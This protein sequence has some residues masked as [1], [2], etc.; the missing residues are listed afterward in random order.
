[1]SGS[2]SASGAYDHV[3]LGYT[4]LAVL[5]VIAAI[6]LGMRSCRAIGPL[7]WSLLLLIA[8]L[9]Y[10]LRVRV[11]DTAIHLR[12]GV[13]LV[14]RT[15]PLS[16]VTAS[17]PIR[18]P[19]LGYGIRWGPRGTL[20]NVSGTHAVQL[21]LRNGRILLIGTDDPQGLDAAIQRKLH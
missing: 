8:I 13:G 18:Y 20:Y 19:P 9:F 7:Y 5:A 21:S 6:P 2:A 14:R 17:K 12:F 16:D 3:Q 10:A 11:D 15:I 1:M 4:I